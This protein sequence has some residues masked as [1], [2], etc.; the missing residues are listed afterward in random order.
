MDIRPIELKNA[1]RFILKLHRHHSRV[2]GHKFS[3]GL[4]EAEA[5]RGVAVCGRPI[6]RRLDDGMTLEVTRVC[7]DGMQNACSKLYGACARIARELGYAKIIT[8]ILEKEAGTSLKASGWQCEANGVGG[9][10]WN[11][12]GKMIRTD[13]VTDLFGTKKKYPNELK[14]RWAKRLRQ[15]VC[16][17]RTRPATNGQVKTQCVLH[18]RFYDVER[19][20][21]PEP[22]RESEGE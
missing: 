13:E 6:G 19:R 10:S 18:C 3:I 14:Q 11:S 21:C 4:F 12:S 15:S 22:N 8:Y 7:T 2:Q 17:A 16:T 5:M 20:C 1:N 9:K